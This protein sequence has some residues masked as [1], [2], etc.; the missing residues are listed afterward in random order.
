MLR[1]DVDE[2]AGALADDVGRAE[3][4]VGPCRKPRGRDRRHRLPHEFGRLGGGFVIPSR[5]ARLLRAEH[6][7]GRH[8]DGKR[9]E[10]ALVRWIVR[11]DD[12]L[13][14]RL[15]RR[16]QGA[17]AAIDRR[18]PRRTGPGEVD[19]HRATGD[20]DRH[21]DRDRGLVDA[22][23]VDD[24]MRLV[25]TVRQRRQ[26]RTG[27]RLARG[28][29]VVEHRLHRRGA[30]ARQRFPETLL[31]D[32]HRREFGLDVAEHERRQPHV[33]GD[34]A[35]HVLDQ[36]VVARQAHARQPQPFLEHGAGIGRQAARLGAA[37]VEQ[38]RH[39]DGE[40]EGLAVAE[41]RADDGEVAGMR[42]ALVGVVGEK[43]V[44][45]RHG[46]REASLDEAD[47][48]AEGTGEQRD[49]VG[50]RQQL[51]LRVA[52]A[53]GE[54]EHLVDHRAHAGAGEHDGHLVN[55]GEQPPAHDL[56]RH[57]GRSGPVT[58]RLRH[59]VQPSRS[60]RAGLSLRAQALPIP[61]TRAAVG[62]MLG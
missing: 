39:R 55:E 10:P 1:L 53:A 47:L 48:G 57:V 32:P 36:P 5:R 50:L 34:D 60:G 25:E 13:V 16:L 35:D 2:A 33:F 9:P 11:P 24:V 27:A 22:V 37:D 58:R 3:T 62:T 19:V 26:R 18:R 51:A 31:G 42:A 61:R 4:E 52:E 46:T 38:M 21:L 6:R 56:A 59:A 7:A 54:V 30:V 40:G 49:A 23:A 29:D 12:R 8:G 20:A 28:Q 43:R 41:D 14:D 15:H 17:G 45:G 44:A